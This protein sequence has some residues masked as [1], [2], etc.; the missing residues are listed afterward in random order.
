MALAGSLTEF[1]RPALL[2]TPDINRRTILVN[3]L[4]EPP[5]RITGITRYLFALL[6]ELVKRDHFQYVLATTWAADKLPAALTM[7]DLRVETLPYHRSLPHNVMR[8]M[9]TLPQLMRQT[10]AV[11]EF[12]CNPVGGFWPIWP[13]VITVHD[14]YFDVTPEYY[15]RRHRLWWRILFPL[16]LR[17]TTAAICVSNSTRADL[18]KHY[19]RQA[20]KAKVVHEASALAVPAKPADAPAST[21]DA[22]HALVVGNIS[23]NKNPGGLAAALQILEERGRP[24]TVAHVGRDEAGLLAGSVADAGVQTSIESLGSLSDVA[25]VAA[26]RGAMFM[27]SASTHEGFCL[28]IL[29]AQSCGTPVACSDIPVLREVAGDAALFFD[30]GKPEMLAD[31]LDRM[32]G[33]PMLRQRLSEAGLENANRFSWARAAMETESVLDAAVSARVTPK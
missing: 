20:G 23:P 5:D 7:S 22:A 31:A 8:Q 17:A 15:P 21:R 32:R 33:D 14:L 6:E 19:P 2:K 9:L 13:R 4:L 30:P 26:Y 27:I 18:C 1:A 16:A 10:G 24:L 25:L 29:E 12:N 28:P 3:H 11:A